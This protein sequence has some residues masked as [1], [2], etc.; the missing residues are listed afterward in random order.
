VREVLVS[1][2]NDCLFRLRKSFE[3]SDVH[4]FSVVLKLRLKPVVAALSDT[5]HAGSIP[6]A[7]TILT[8]L[9]GG[10]RAKMPRIAAR[11]FVTFMVNLLV[12][13]R[14]LGV[15]EL[16][17]KSM[18][19]HVLSI[20]PE[21]TVAMPV[22]VPE[23]YPARFPFSFTNEGPETAQIGSPTFFRRGLVL[24]RKISGAMRLPSLV[25]HCAP[26]APQIS[27]ILATIHRTLTF[28]PGQRVVYSAMIPPSPVVHVAPSALAAGLLTV[29]NGTLTQH[30]G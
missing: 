18:S 21:R 5:A 26:T 27:A 4:T 30:H 15:V 25:M 14:L 29:I 7:F 19:E 16:V 13:Q 8:V 23:P 12:A 1:C 28:G 3:R 2:R 24:H 20:G 9:L 22:C 17:A 6:S 10:R 11:S